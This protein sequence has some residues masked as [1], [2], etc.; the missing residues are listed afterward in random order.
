[1]DDPSLAA[2]RKDTSAEPCPDAGVNDEIQLTFVD[3]SHAHS[4]CVEMLRE[5]VPPPA[6]IIGGAPSDTT[7]LTGL[8]LVLTVEDVPHPDT[9][10]ATTSATPAVNNPRWRTLTSASIPPQASDRRLRC[11]QDPFQCV[12]GIALRS[13]STLKPLIVSCR[14]F[15]IVDP[16]RLL[17]AAWPAAA[18]SGSWG[19]EARIRRNARNGS[20]RRAHPLIPKRGIVPGIRTEGTSECA[21][22]SAA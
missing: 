6:S 13:R 18:W 16:L 12:R 21:L 15:P 19:Q 14:H 2:T 22:G 7:H 11:E 8:G 9:R 20:N 10:T 3:A 1:M 5:P 4:G 17:R